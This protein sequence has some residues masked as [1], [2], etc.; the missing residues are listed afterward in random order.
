MIYQISQISNRDLQ[1]LHTYRILRHTSKTLSAMYR[2]DMPEQYTLLKPIMVERDSAECYEYHIPLQEPTTKIPF[3]EFDCDSE[4]NLKHIEDFTEIEITSTEMILRSTSNN[5]TEPIDIRVYWVLSL[6]QIA[7]ILDEI[8]NELAKLR[9]ELNNF[10]TDI[11]NIRISEKPV[12]N[13]N[14]QVPDLVKI[15]IDEIGMIYDDSLFQLS[16]ALAA[17]RLI[18]ASQAIISRL[19]KVHNGVLEFI[20]QSRESRVFQGFTGGILKIRGTF[21]NLV[22]RDV[23]SSII[24]DDI[25]ADFVLIDNCQAVMFGKDISD[26]LGSSGTI[27][28]MRIRT[29]NVVIRQS[30]IIT[31]LEL[32]SRALLMQDAG[33]IR[34]VRFVDAS[35]TL[36]HR[37]GDIDTIAPSAIQGTYQTLDELTLKQRTVMFQAGQTENPIPLQ[38]VNVKIKVTGVKPEPSPGPGPSPSPDPSDKIYTPYSDWYWSGDSRTVGLINAVGCAGQGYGGQGLS[39]LRQVT[40]DVVSGGNQKN[41]LLW[42]GVN[43]LESGYADVYEHIAQAAGS[44]SVVFVATVG[45]VFNTSGL[46][47]SEDTIGQEGGYG[48]T[49]IAQ[50]NAN[51]QSFNEDL[52][53]A[54]SAYSDIYVLDVWDYIENTLMADYSQVQLSAGVGNGLH[55]SNICYQKIYDWVNNQIINAQPSAWESFSPVGEAGIMTIYDGLRQSGFSKNAA[56]GAIANMKHESNWIAHMIGYNSTYFVSY[57]SRSQE[58]LLPYMDA[59]NSR[60]DLYNRIQ[61]TYDGHSADVLVGYGL[62]Q[63]TS[64]EN[65]GNLYDYHMS[66]GL[67][68][69]TLG[70]QIPAFIKVLR[71]NQY[72]D[73]VNAKQT[74]GDAAYYLCVYYERPAHVDTEK[75]ERYN[76]ANALAQRY[77]FYD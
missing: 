54:L 15:G 71:D 39:K 19:L 47:D 46:P 2:Y 31:E 9:T 25:D 21:K 11:E 16:G 8:T 23:E 77:D 1:L 55:Y 57:S 12:V 67:A 13:K 33:V 58:S 73:E 61:A 28:K 50:F 68:Y 26:L 56:I 76:E 34:T 6:K 49:T 53:T 51:I 5:L 22:L 3:L 20:N 10:D 64:Q 60:L 69:D 27:E 35:S 30:I 32:W 63:F 24:L 41:I 29:S 17:Q 59:A 40:G 72:W 36:C 43:G 48:S 44:D 62:T 7:S 37:N 74:P 38:K 65:I 70:V 75:W 18:N 14:S 42:W 45:R 52:K 66:T 4:T